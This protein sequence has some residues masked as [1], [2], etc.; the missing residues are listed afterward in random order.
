MDFGAAHVTQMALGAWQAQVLY[1]LSELDVFELLSEKP[2]SAQEVA[3]RTG[4]HPLAAEGL[5]NAGVALKLLTRDGDAYADTDLAL[6][7]LC[8]DS[9]E[10]LARWVRVMGRWSRPWNGLTEVVRTG[11]PAEGREARLWQDPRYTAD[12]VLGMHEYARRIADEV[13]DHA[14]LPPGARVT[15][16]GGG[17]GT[18]A[19]ALCRRHPDVS[20]RILELASVLP[21]AERT[22]AEAGLAD[23]IDVTAG[24]YLTDPFGTDVSAVLLSNILHQESREAGESIVGRAHRALRPG[25]KLVVNGYFL[26]ES[27]TRPLFT[28]LHNLSAFTLWGGGRSYTVGE[29]AAL[30]R[31]AGFTEPVVHQ[32]AQGASTVLVAEKAEGPEGQHP[33]DRR[34]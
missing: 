14:D 21:I 15:D 7:L 13:A 9:P 31:S 8:E 34:E 25:G 22:V 3:R 33:A 18:Y 11:R 26:D 17:A 4:A 1:T 30:L 16:V 10:S 19:I 2:L 23:R 28:T 29:A 32:V 5:L 20:V 12:F 27:R 24:D 6:R